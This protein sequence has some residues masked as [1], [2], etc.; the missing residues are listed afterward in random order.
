VG[1]SPAKVP[2]WASAIFSIPVY[3]FQVK[4]LPYSTMKIL[5]ISAKL[6]LKFPEGAGAAI[7]IYVSAKCCGSTGSGYTTLEVTIPNTGIP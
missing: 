6:A 3:F 4:F 7:K 5:F 1:S 2:A